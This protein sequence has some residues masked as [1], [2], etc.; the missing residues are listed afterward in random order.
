MGET[1]NIEDFKRNQKDESLKRK[2]KIIQVGRTMRR[3]IFV[4]NIKKL[5][6]QLQ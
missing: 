4:S 6:S 1:I 5:W 3:K 2:S